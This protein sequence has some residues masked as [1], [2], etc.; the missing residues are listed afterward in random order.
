MWCTDFCS[1]R[2]SARRRSSFG[3]CGVLRTNDD[4][5]DFVLTAVSRPLCAIASLGSKR[6]STRVTWI[7]VTFL[8]CLL[9]CFVDF[10]SLERACQVFRA[11]CPGLVPEDLW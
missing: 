5:F 9:I 1:N 2:R 11:S 3:C 4:E 8:M 6:R 10:E 7:F